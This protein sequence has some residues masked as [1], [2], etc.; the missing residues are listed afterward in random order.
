MLKRILSLLLAGLL[1]VLFYGCTK[2]NE[3]KDKSITIFHAGSL[4]VPLLEMKKEFK[5]LHPGTE[6]YLEPAGSRMCARKIADLNKPCDVMMSADYT[7]INQILI[8]KFASWCIKFASNQMAIVYTDRS[9]YS[10]E[11]NSKNWYKILERPDVVCGHSDPNQDPC[12]YRAV[13]TMKLASLYYKDPGIYTRLNSKKNGMLNRPKETDFISLLQTGEVDYIFLYK[14]VAV[15]HGLKYVELPPQ[16]NLSSIKYTDFY[17]KATVEIS[18]NEPGTKIS[19]SGEPIIYGLTIPKNSE[20]PKLADEFVKF[21]LSKDYG[22]EIMDKC[23]QAPV[24]P[25]VSLTY[26]SIPEDLKQFALPPKK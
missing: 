6:I 26:K 25:E 5:K 22:L 7:V 3:V 10:K 4:S 9:K 21:V 11:I 17:K 23:G 12:G 16:I 15:Q 19:K 1:P 20:N 14:S 24:V 2:N 8:P 13:I 18:G